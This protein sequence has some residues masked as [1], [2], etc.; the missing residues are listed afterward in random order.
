MMNAIKTGIRMV[1]FIVALILVIVGQKN[2]GPIGLMTMLLG[3]SFLIWL[4]N[5]YNKK[6]R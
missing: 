1:L 4:L 6:Y 5:D 2:V 3:V